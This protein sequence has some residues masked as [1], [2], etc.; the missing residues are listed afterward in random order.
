MT[1]KT[2]QRDPIEQNDL[3]LTWPESDLDCWEDVCEGSQAVDNL[4]EQAKAVINED[5][6]ELVSDVWQLMFGLTP[7][8]AD[9]IKA[10]LVLNRALLL[11]LSENKEF[12]KLRAYSELDPFLSTYGAIVLARELLDA[13]QSMQGPDGAPLAGGIGQ[14]EG[15]GQGEGKP[16]QGQG[17][18]SKGKGQGK[19]EPQDGEGKGEDNQPQDG[20]SEGEGDKAGNTECPLSDQD[21]RDVINKALGNT[22]EKV[23]DLNESQTTCG[24]QAGREAAH[25]GYNLDADRVLSIAST[26]EHNEKLKKIS[27]LAGR[28]VNLS[29]GMR[30]KRVLDA[31]AEIH[32]VKLG[33]DIT[34][35]VPSELINLAIPE[36]E[37]SFHQ[38][39]LDSTLQQY[40][41]QG[42]GRAGK[43]PIVMCIDASG[44]MSDGGYY[45]YRDHEGVSAMYWA[46]ACFLAVAEMARRENRHLHVCWF[47]QCVFNDAHVDP[48]KDNFKTLTKYASTDPRGGTNFSAAL[49]FALNVIEKEH[50]FGK[51]DIIFVTDGLCHVDE[52]YVERFNKQRKERDINVFLALILHLHDDKEYERECASYQKQHEDWCDRSI[53]INR[54]DKK[55]GNVILAEHLLQVC[56]TGL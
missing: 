56:T 55:Q 4:R 16:G 45:G 46:N 47:D 3:C 52:D 18:P 53:V 11:S 2:T 13:L 5:S 40:E 36:L 32:D 38:R 26:L 29:D 8:L 27:R 31:P 28:I 30:S 43:G 41:I 17:Q 20:E 7:E 10:P 1:A 24:L 39:Y 49:D 25:H 12:Q 44:S 48:S 19:G 35:L 23:E 51:A 33:N 9:E 6:A 50:Q 42:E 14:N 15:E 34:R 37:D 54:S 22:N 21:I